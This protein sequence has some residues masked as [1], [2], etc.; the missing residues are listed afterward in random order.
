[1][2]MCTVIGAGSVATNLRNAR[3][4]KCKIGSLI[5][6]ARAY[7]RKLI[8]YCTIVTEKAKRE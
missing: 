4:G 2:D 7:A 5:F 1:M 8:C 3:N 6:H